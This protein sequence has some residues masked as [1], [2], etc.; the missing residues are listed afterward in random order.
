[1]E[2]THLKQLLDLEW[3]GDDN[4]LG[5]SPHYPWGRVYG[6]QAVAQAL[7]AAGQTVEPRF[8]PHS[9]HAYFIRGGEIDRP[10]RYSV[11]RIRDGRSFVTRRVVG[12][13]D[14][15]VKGSRAIMN[16]SASFQMAETEAEVMTNGLPD[17]PRPGE[18]EALHTDPEWS[19][20]FSR[21]GL[22]ITDRGRA[23]S[24][25]RIT[26]EVDAD[27]YL[28]QASVIAY[29]SD[30]VPTESVLNAHPNRGSD[31]DLFD[32][33]MTTSLD[34]AIWF[35]QFGGSND[36]MLHDFHCTAMRGA[37]GHASGRI[38]ASDGRHLATVAQE[39]L[40]RERPRS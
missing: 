4:F 2:P 22:P 39:V 5:H 26:D 33:F 28:L 1:M 36:W 40:L 34:H 19:P 29:I 7:W 20:M 32:R 23:S 31:E 9:M 11:D 13:Q 17:V 27:D 18:F 3:L 21:Q 30:D 14:D 12:V 8:L 25:T 6:G 38:Y 24:W 15:V 16:L 10:I 35:H 37:R